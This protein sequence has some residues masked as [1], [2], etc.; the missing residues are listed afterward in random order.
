MTRADAFATEVKQM[1]APFLQGRKLDDDPWLPTAVGAAIEVHAQVL[2]ARGERPEAVAYLGEQLKQ[3]A[4]TSLTERIRKNINLLSL[5]GKPAPAAGLGTVD[6]RAGT[7][8]GRAA[9]TPRAALFLAHCAATARPKWRSS[10]ICGKTF[11]PQDWWSSDRRGLYGYVGG[12]ED[13]AAG[14]GENCTSPQVRSKFLRSAR[15]YG[16][17]SERGE[18][19]GLMEPAARL[20]LVLIDRAG[21]VRW[22]HPGSATEP[23]SP[24][25][26]RA[27]SRSSPASTRSCV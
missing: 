21:I 10:R 24:L 14:E 3:F 18:L 22:Y 12:G 2:A 17:A 8:P 9:R 1:A 25:A 11:A 7:I 26:S 4:A 19:S 20:P 27:F 23:N 6:R 15:R 13:C 5:E 16:R